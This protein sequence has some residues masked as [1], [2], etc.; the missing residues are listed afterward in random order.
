MRKVGGEGVKIDFAHKNARV[1][2][3]KPFSVEQLRSSLKQISKTK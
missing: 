2:F 3:S 1:H